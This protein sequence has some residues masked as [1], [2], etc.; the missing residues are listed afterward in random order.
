MK[1]NSTGTGK[2]RLKCIGCDAL[3]RTVYMCAAQSP[4]VVDVSLFRLGLHREPADLRELLQ[5]TVDSTVGQGYDAIVV[6]YG[7]CGKATAGLMARDT[8]L[9]IPRAHDCIT[10]FLGDRRRYEEEFRECPG[11]YWYVADYIERVEGRGVTLSIGAES[12]ADISTVYDEYV[13]KYGKDNA[14]YLMEVMGAWQAHYERAAYIDMGVS[15]SSAVEQQAKDEAEQR[16]WDFERLMGDVTLIRR[17][18]GGDWDEDFLVLE[19]GQHIAPSYGF[20]V[21]GAGTPTGSQPQPYG[22]GTEA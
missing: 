20:E 18:M 1:M 6:A 15:D 12:T 19:P 8:Q 4:H 9:I 7:L 3:A 16:G 11:T 5:A 10:L 14:D 21:I 17:L 2:M 13:E 22:A